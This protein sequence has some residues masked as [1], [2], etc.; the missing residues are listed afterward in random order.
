MP[1]GRP[2]HD[3]WRCYGDKKKDVARKG[4][5]RPCRGCG[6]LIPLNSAHR[7]IAHAEQCTELTRMGLWKGQQSISKFVQSM[8]PGGKCNVDRMVGRFFY[9]HAIPFIASGSAWF[10][11]LMSQHIAGYC[12]PSPKVLG[13]SLLVQVYNEEMEILRGDYQNSY[14][15][16]SMDAW[17][18]PHCVVGF[19]MD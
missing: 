8:T 9:A 19:S 7:A 18:G 1:G 11:M 16:L 10:R 13:S 2:S 3:V 6:K 14:V 12:P 4:E 17:T 15:T 5:Y